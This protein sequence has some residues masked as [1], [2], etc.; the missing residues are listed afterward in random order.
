MIY[1]HW[2]EWL[3]LGLVNATGTA[4]GALI[5]KGQMA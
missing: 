4:I 1:L 5:A 2:T 3:L